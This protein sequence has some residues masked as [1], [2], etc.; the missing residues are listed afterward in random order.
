ML[1]LVAF[2]Q[3]CRFDTS[4]FFWGIKL[5]LLCSPGKK[6]VQTSVI[7]YQT[8]TQ[9]ATSREIEAS[10]GR[11][12]FKTAGAFVAAPAYYVHYASVSLRQ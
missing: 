2:Y 7:Q 4:A 1:E 3:H 9:Y 11:S 8:S 6:A 5:A 10:R 12:L